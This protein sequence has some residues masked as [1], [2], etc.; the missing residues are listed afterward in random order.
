MKKFKELQDLKFDTIREVFVFDVFSIKDESGK[1]GYTRCVENV[2]KALTKKKLNWH[3]RQRIKIILQ[4]IDRLTPKAISMLTS[5]D[6]PVKIM[7]CE[8]DKEH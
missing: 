5:D 6:N 7:M 1:N 3:E 2:H 4:F 8:Y